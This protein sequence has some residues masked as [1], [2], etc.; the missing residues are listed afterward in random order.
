MLKL[1]S[2]TKIFIHRAHVDF[3][4]SINGLSEIVQSEMKLDPFAQ[5][6]FVF[7]SRDRRKVKLLYWDRTGFALWMKRL[8]E[9]K[10]P[11]PRKFES[12]VIEF[13]VKELEWLLEGYEFWKMRPHESLKYACVS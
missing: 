4:K 10:F 12:E 2:F 9:A 5:Y 7:G 6:L 11:W 3:R 1:D 8:E 13:T